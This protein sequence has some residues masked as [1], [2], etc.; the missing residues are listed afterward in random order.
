MFDIP[1][2]RKKKKVKALLPELEQELELLQH[3]VRALGIP[4]IIVLEGYDACGKGTVINH[5]IRP[6]DARGY[7]V[8]RITEPTGMEKKYPYLWRFWTRM[9][10][11]GQIAIFDRAWYSG[12]VEDWIDQDLSMEEVNRTYRYITSFEK[13]QTDRGAVLL[14]F[15]LAI[16]KK[17]QKARFAEMEKEDGRGWQITSRNWKHHEQFDQY[18]IV[19]NQ[20]IQQTDYADAPWHVV[21]AEEYESGLAQVMECIVKVLRNKVAQAVEDRSRRNSLLE[22]RNLLSKEEL[23]AFK[24][25]ELL[26]QQAGKR[27]PLT[28]V[29]LDQEMDYD[30]YKKKL[31]ACQKKLL[32][33]HSRIHQAGIPVILVFEGWD[34]SGKGGAIRRLTHCLDVRGFEVFSADK[35]TDAEKQHHY[36]W[37]FWK[38]MPRKGHI[39]I[40]DRSWYSRVMDERVDGICTEQEWR[41][42]YDEINEMELQLSESGAIVLKFWM[43]IDKDT[44]MERFTERQNS[45]YKSWKMS[46]DDWKHREKWDLYEPA[47][48]DM[49]RK[50]DR[51][52][53]PWII[54]ESNNKYYARIKVLTSVIE[55]FKRGL[56]STER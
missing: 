4:V 9:P 31:K 45:I 23:F 36:L 3:Q 12:V 53:A 32:E 5:L 46:E 52:G 30:S 37:R 14:K 17:E 49:L 38:H 28:E 55:A 15:F 34:A 8:H 6:F 43:Q 48:N 56:E 27:K 7:V 40:F 21:N 10:A 16:S 44:Q 50:T 26:D 35:P 24:L 13:L 19:Y 39:T 22:Q 25:Q 33:L 51:D 18:S 29:V 54:V 42:A 11:S 47:V 2:K 1:E 41:K 20:L